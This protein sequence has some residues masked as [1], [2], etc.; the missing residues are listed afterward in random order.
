MAVY[1]EDEA[2][3]SGQFCTH[4]CQESIKFDDEVFLLSLA[5]PQIIGEHFLFSDAL[6]DDGDYLYEPCF[7]C[8]N[9][10]EHLEE[11]IRTQTKDT[12]PVEDDYAILECS[13]CGSGIRANEILGTIQFGELTASRRTPNGERAAMY[14]AQGQKKVICIHCLNVLNNDIVDV[15]WTHS[16][17][18]HAECQEGCALRCWRHGCDADSTCPHIKETE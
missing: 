2:E 4:P 17:V 9:C 15:L 7:F 10:W 11:E 3:R 5:Y 1:I 6:Y 13:T 12:P 16:V 14:V 8:V 18:Q